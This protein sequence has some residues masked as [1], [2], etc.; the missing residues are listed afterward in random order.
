MTQRRPLPG[1][2]SDRSFRVSAGREAGIA[3]SRL[4]AADLT[5]P[6]HGIR[7]AGG[8]GHT[9]AEYARALRPRLPE[10][11]FFSHSSAAQLIGVP[12]PARL[13]TALPVHVG[14]AA[15]HKVVTARDIVGHRLSIE[16]QDVVDW[17]DLRITGAARTWLDLAGMLDLAD[18]VA[19][20]DYL[21][22]WENPLTV[23]AELTDAASR[24]RGRR[25]RVLIRAALPMLRDRAESPR[26]SRLR[27]IIVLAG[28][29]EPLCNYN[30]FDSTGRFVAR[31]D[32]AY[33]QF[34]LLLEY[35]GDQHRTDRAQWR[36]DIRRLG[37]VED[38]Q[39]QV[40]QFTDDDV[41]APVQLVTRIERR[42]RARGWRG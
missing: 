6:F 41:R 11:A 5:T 26:E 21:I 40:L 19:A 20:G 22:H 25:G 18:L 28:L 30:V 29:P 15:P 10:E 42:L 31:A 14:V 33:P 32:L 38:E 4:R 39:W 36:R 13:Q 8:F 35:Q 1:E 3:R 17:R 27:V 7:S 9:V 34:R 2:F 37:E 12:L 24:Y 23:L 16:D